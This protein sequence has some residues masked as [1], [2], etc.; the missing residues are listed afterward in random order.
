MAQVNTHMVNYRTFLK[1]LGIFLFTGS[2]LFINEASAQLT[3]PDLAVDY[4]YGY[5]PVA[6]INNDWI[7]AGNYMG[8]GNPDN[9]TDSGFHATFNMVMKNGSAP[10]MHQITNATLSDV[11]MKG[12]DTLMQGTVTVTMKDGPVSDVPTNWTIYNNNSIAI[13]MDP[14]KVNNHFGSTPI[15]GLELN[16]EKEMKTMNAMMEDAK[17][18]DKWI[19]MMMQNMM[20]NS[21]LNGKNMSLMPVIINDS[22]GGNNSIGLVG[23]NSAN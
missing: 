21:N 18:M 6:S 4:E 8:Y 9:L 7:L 11:T 13:S 2:L 1:I 10:H 16:P 3:L 5:G 20:Q 17:F 14:A 22:Q 23:N 19:P 15:Y 12:N